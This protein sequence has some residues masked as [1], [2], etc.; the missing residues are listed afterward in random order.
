L[1]ATQVQILLH[2]RK[3]SHFYSF[4]EAGA[5]FS[6]MEEVLRRNRNA[7]LHKLPTEC[8]LKLFETILHS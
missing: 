8:V 5:E 7:N 2:A 6:E 3:V 4:A 1:T